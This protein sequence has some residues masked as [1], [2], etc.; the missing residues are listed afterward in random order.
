MTK[1]DGLFPPDLTHQLAQGA[2]ALTTAEW[3]KFFWLP[4]NLQ[5]PP[6]PYHL[7]EPTKDGAAA[8]SDRVLCRGHTATSSKIPAGASRLGMFFVFVYF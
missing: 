6:A 5:G 4:Y 3:K 2:V 1:A 7:G 8:W